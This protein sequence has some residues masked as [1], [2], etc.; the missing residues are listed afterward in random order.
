MHREEG[1]ALITV[2]LTIMLATMAIGLFSFFVVNEYRGHTTVQE[3]LQGQY[4][5]EAGIE[6]TLALLFFEPALANEPNCALP[7]DVYA[8][9]DFQLNVRCTRDADTVT[10]LSN[11]V[12]DELNYEVEA[13]LLATVSEDDIIT[14]LTLQRWER[15]D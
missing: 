7:E 4:A 1:F 5:A 6:Q 11:A 2:L 10:I 9:K 3:Q 8:P 15:H 13:V 12:S 14:E